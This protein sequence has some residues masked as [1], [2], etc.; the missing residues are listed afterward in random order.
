MERFKAPLG[1][2]EKIFNDAKMYSSGEPKAPGIL[3]FREYIYWYWGVRK[4]G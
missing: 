2:A 1:G 4:E 3:I